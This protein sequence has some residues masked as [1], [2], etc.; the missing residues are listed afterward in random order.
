MT[1]RLVFLLL[2][3]V[4]FAAGSIQ[5][6]SAAGG[7]ARPCPSGYQTQ[8]V[9]NYLSSNG[10]AVNNPAFYKD[11]KLSTL[12]IEAGDYAMIGEGIDRTVPYAELCGKKDP[13]NHFDLLSMLAGALL[14]IVGTIAILRYLGPKLRGQT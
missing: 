7:E 9:T 3:G 12:H 2:L 5:S 4:L 14:G 10:F 8:F 13:E 6:V 1:R 11:P